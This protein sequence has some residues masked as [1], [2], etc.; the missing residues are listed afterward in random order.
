MYRGLSSAAPDNLPIAT[1]LANQVSC[2]PLYTARTDE[3]GERV[4]ACVTL[5]EPCT[6]PS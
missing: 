3:D 1:R 4:V 6:L 2:L 5:A